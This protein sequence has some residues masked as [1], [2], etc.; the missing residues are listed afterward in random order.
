MR[1]KIPIVLTL[2]FLYSCACNYV[3]LDSI[4]NTKTPFEKMMA[5]QDY[6]RLKKEARP[7]VIALEDD[8]SNALI[9]EPATKINETRLSYI[10]GGE[11]DKDEAG[12]LKS[13]FFEFNQTSLLKEQK[14]N[15]K[16]NALEIS[17]NPHITVL[18]SAHSDIIGNNEYNKKLSLKRAKNVFNHL[19][20]EGVDKKR[21]SIHVAGTDNPLTEIEFKPIETPEQLE[22]YKQALSRNRR[23]NFIIDSVDG[24][25]ADLNSRL[26]SN[27]NKPEIT[28]ST[29]TQKTETS[30]DS[31]GPQSLVFNSNSKDLSE[32]E[33]LKLEKITED[34]KMMPNK[35]LFVAVNV[36][37]TSE[38]KIR[39]NLQLVTERA[40]FIYAYFIAK[41]LSPKQFSIKISKIDAQVKSIH[42]NNPC[43]YRTVSF[44]YDDII[45]LDLTAGPRIATENILSG[46]L[47]LK[48][49]SFL[50]KSSKLTQCELNTILENFSKISSSSGYLFTAH[51]YIKGSS[52]K[53]ININRRLALKRM[54]VLNALIR[55][56]NL[57]DKISISLHTPDI[58]KTNEN[59]FNS[60]YRHINFSK[61]SIETN[62]PVATIATVETNEPITAPGPTVIT[63]IAFKS[64]SSIL[65]PGQKDL[66]TVLLDQLTN[67][68]NSKISASLYIKGSSPK[69]IK[70]NRRLAEAR[71]R[72]LRAIFEARGLGK[73]VEINIFT[74][75]VDEAFKGQFHHN[76]RQVDFTSF[77]LQQ[78]NIS[79]EV[80]E[81]S[82]PEVERDN[83]ELIKTLFFKKGR[84]ELSKYSR[85]SLSQAI[86]QIHFGGTS[87]LHIVSYVDRHGPKNYNRNLAQKRG[88]N[89]LNKLGQLGIAKNK[90]R[91]MIKTN[92][93]SPAEFSQNKNYYRRVEI[94]KSD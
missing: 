28:Y 20:S 61:K 85:Y 35:K 5:E 34:F 12:S 66:L 72:A 84:T 91:V 33:A 39:S 19:I 82:L 62:P 44:K 43:I 83:T 18:I 24:I 94:L 41:G 37:G 26:A 75:D 7:V 87:L 52:P 88:D 67:N 16:S 51:I 11:S 1:L 57:N 71:E 77:D 9:R 73:Q 58:I 54:E 27:E 22:Y 64:K 46:S 56:K 21:L 48:T 90:I 74:P 42:K 65:P 49:V 15:L 53:I 2:L 81:N 29:P 31:S 3:V 8:S 69:S 50:S 10:L 23:V 38:E 40:S 63:P 55:S 32:T 70:I 59:Y 60:N 4:V 89:I 92:S 68:P 36:K 47:D 13:L 79:S 25:K 45:P 93:R 78:R 86:S 17:K 80:V 30:V 14:D 76:Y 6:E